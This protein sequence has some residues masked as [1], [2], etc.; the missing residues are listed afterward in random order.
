[1]HDDRRSREISGSGR[2][3]GSLLRTQAPDHSAATPGIRTETLPRGDRTTDSLHPKS[4]GAR[5]LSVRSETAPRAAPRS[6]SKLFGSEGRGGNENRGERRA[7]QVTAKDA[8]IFAG[9]DE[10]VLGR[11]ADECVSN[12]RN[13]RFG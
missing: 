1:M 7:N 8:Q 9:P 3:N 11:R 4:A 13:D 12:S 5:L 6:A 10:V 2:G